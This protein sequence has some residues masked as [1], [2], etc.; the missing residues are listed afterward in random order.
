MNKPS[1]CVHFSLCSGCAI[2][3]PVDAPVWQEARAY[4]H[5]KGIE[6][7]IYTDGFLK[8]RMKAKLAIR[9]GPQIGLFKKG[10]H[11]ILPIPHCLV[12]HPSI[13]EAVKIVKE[14]MRK[15]N[16]RAYDES[17]SG[18][19]LRYM[20]CFVDR[21]TSRVQLVLVA[22][23]EIDSFCASLLK[24]DLWHS[25][26]QNIQTASTN[27]IFGSTWKHFYGE[28]F[29]WQPIGKDLFPFHP[30]A[31]SQVHFPLYEKMLE[32]IDQWIP[33]HQKIIE[34]YAGVGVI[35]LS[36]LHKAKALTLVENNPYAYLSFQQMRKNVPYLCID[37]ECAD[38]QGYDVTIVDP[39][40]KGLGAALIAK[41]ASSQLIYVSC[42]FNSFKNDAEM[43]IKQGWRL[44][45]AAGYLLFPGTN[46]VEIVSRFER[47]L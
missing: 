7:A 16:I 12:H 23:E 25:I 44:T 22:T 35:G 14:E 40:R 3:E 10:T 42:D 11:E 2:D 21:K 45:N 13:N 47:N 6:P 5:E 27:A 41:I 4:F 26:W 18:G 1:A 32:K 37:A 34:L 28:S 46:H 36:L 17:A 31:F 39:P 29:L 30:A 20:Q 9:P 43:L 8:T 38:T 15:Q 24:Y 33:P 19:L